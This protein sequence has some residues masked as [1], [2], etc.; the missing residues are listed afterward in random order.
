MQKTDFF[1]IK[2]SWWNGF[3]VRGIGF[4]M[5]MSAFLFDKKNPFN[6]RIIL[7]ILLA[8]GMFIVMLVGNFE[9]IN[10]RFIRLKKAIFSFFAI[11]III[12]FIVPN[13]FAKSLTA[14]PS[15]IS[16]EYTLGDAQPAD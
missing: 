1:G 4:L 16:I 15:A 10:L 11:G 3:M 14:L 12:I 2:M 8:M 6:T 7:T 13:S 5:I 9:R